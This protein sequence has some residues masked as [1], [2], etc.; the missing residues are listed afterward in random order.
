MKEISEAEL[1]EAVQA[2]DGAFAVFFYTPTCGTCKAAAR[3]H[4]VVEALLTE[5]PFYSCNVNFAPR[6]VAEWQIRSVPCTGLVR[7]GQPA[8]LRYRMG[9]AGELYRYYQQQ[10][11][12]NN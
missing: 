2:G 11:N 1:L 12:V 6:L 10:L 9:D 4:E 8:G 3:M 7:N 5:L